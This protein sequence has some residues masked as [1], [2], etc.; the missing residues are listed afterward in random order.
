MAGSVHPVTATAVVTEWLASDGNVAPQA[1][2]HAEAF[3]DFIVDALERED[4]G[5]PAAAAATTL[6]A[7][8]AAVRDVDWGAVLNALIKD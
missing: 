6:A 7:L 1:K 4:G 5:L 2:Y 3:R 8:D